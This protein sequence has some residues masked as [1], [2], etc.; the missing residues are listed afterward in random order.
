MI[1][2]LRA[3]SP[4][5]SR[6]V[7][8]RV[9]LPVPSAL[10][11]LLLVQAVFLSFD[12]PVPGQ[13]ESIVNTKHNLSSSGP[14][15][16]RA[17]SEDRICIFCHT[18]HAARS[19]APLWNREDS[20]ASYIPYDSPTLKAQ[21][22]QPT[23]ASK[24]CLSC[25]DG[26]IAL[27]DLVSESSPIA[28]SGSPTMPAGPGLIGTDLR[29][30][31]PISFAY[32]ES[33]AALPG[34]L[35]PPSAWDPRVALDDQ[36]ML[37]CTTC[38]DPHD[39]QWGDFLV[40]DNLQSMLCR[41]C[42]TLS[43]F[44]LTPHAQ[45]TATW[46]GGG[47]D[48]WPHTDYPDV[49]SNACLNCHQNHHA[50][51][52]EA[53]V[54]YDREEDVCLVC[55]DGNVASGDLATVFRKP[56]RHPVERNQGAHRG[57]EPPQ[58]AWNH[59][60]CVDCHNPHQA[61]PIPG[62]P[63]FVMGV[64][65]GVSGVNAAELPV[66][67]AAYEYE[68]CF[69]CH[70]REAG[71]G[72]MSIRRQISTTNVAREFSPSSPSYHPVEVPVVGGVSPSLLTSLGAGSQIYCSDCHGNDDPAAE[73]NGVAG[74]HG[75]DVEFLLKRQ[76][77]TGGYATESAATYAL[78]YGCHSQGSILGD[79]SFPDHNRHIVE[80]QTPCSVC[81]DPHG[82]DY[83]EGTPLNHAH[84]INFDISVV[85]PDTVTGFL[86]YRSLGPGTGECYLTC[87]GVPHSPRRY[88]ED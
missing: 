53:L 24:L 33:L 67:E 45:S 72:F 40:M 60:E 29:D 28:M 48:P 73:E 13:N 88:P 77:V 19:V 82:I 49:Q 52:A 8:A 43:F 18:P 62:Q 22:G 41:E 20:T 16:V 9:R 74:P 42:H 31:H 57:G 25:H 10:S 69:K 85:N 86:E 65:E 38:H 2:F 1:S 71:A 11:M 61:R 50:G 63:P 55:H 76:Y 35:S 84:L 56:F 30:D 64:L 3:P 37:Q 47:S 83:G 15:P 79:E 14:G 54:T 44:D 58:N 66:E 5:C 68:V 23:G 4:L 81:H 78:C 12:T 7:S 27:G 26:T 59:A 70:A 80:E 21:P 46:N 6:R 87:H 51:G 17:V 32:S 39:D 75:S 34:A 36:G